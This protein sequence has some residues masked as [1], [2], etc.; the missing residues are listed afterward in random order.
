ME[1]RFIL[2]DETNGR[3]IGL[4]APLGGRQERPLHMSIDAGGGGAESVRARNVHPQ[5]KLE[6]PPQKGKKR[7]KKRKEKKEEERRRKQWSKLNPRTRCAVL[8]VAAD[9]CGEGVGVAG[10]RREREPHPNL[11][12]AD[13]IP[14]SGG[15][16]MDRR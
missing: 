10:E 16:V 8:E 13:A 4:Q 1:T 15:E 12:L 7:R 9:L 2:A 11:A 3:D 5:P 14:T 6:S